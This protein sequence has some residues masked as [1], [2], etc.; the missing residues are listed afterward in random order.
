MGSAPGLVTEICWN[1]CKGSVKHK[2][3]TIN[4]HENGSEL[5][6]EM[7]KSPCTGI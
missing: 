5:D 7:Q 1:R 4:I 2:K 3:R 6:K